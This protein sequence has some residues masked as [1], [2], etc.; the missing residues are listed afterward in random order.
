MKK[1]LYKIKDNSI[2]VIIGNNILKKI[3]YSNYIKNKDV[4]IITNKKCV[5]ILF[6]LYVAYITL[7]ITYVN[8]IY[9][10]ENK[11]NINSSNWLK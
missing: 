8:Y 10:N 2:P 3:N 4:V 5:F 9:D 11:I 7:Q 1:I 6:I